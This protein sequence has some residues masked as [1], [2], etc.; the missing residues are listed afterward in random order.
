MDKY[1]QQLQPY[2]FIQEQ[3]FDPLIGNCKGI[4]E[5]ATKRE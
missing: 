5:N 4:G 3:R 1:L 2:T